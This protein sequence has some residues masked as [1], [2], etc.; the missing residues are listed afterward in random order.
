MIVF[1]KKHFFEWCVFA[2]ISLIACVL[3]AVR[4][5]PSLE[6]LNDTGRYVNELHGYCAGAPTND[7][8]Q[9]RKISFEI[10]YFFTSPSC[11]IESNKLFL[12]LV[13]SC[14]PLMFLMFSS[15]KNGT[16]IWAS[17]LL[18]SMYGVE[19][20]TNAMRQGLA[21]LIFFGG[22]SLLRR[23][24]KAA[25]AMGLLACA[26]HTSVLA[27]MP[28]MWWLSGI[29][30]HVKTLI[31]LSLFFTLSFIVIFVVKGNVLVEVY[32]GIS[33]LISYYNEMYEGNFNTLFILFITLP[34]Y[35]IHGLRY[36]LERKTI[37]LYERK[38]FLYSNILLIVSLI[39]YPVIA[40]RFAIFAIPLQIFIITISS[41]PGLIVGS[42]VLI[43]MCSHLVAM[44][45]LT[46]YY[47]VLFYG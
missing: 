19:L 5:I 8:L 16:I 22:V 46:D 45:F 27:F 47:L 24:T 44:Q 3:L 28:L 25:F 18:F 41:R 37:S 13:A 2:L 21:M 7:I 6:S 34:L 38:S 29:R 33:W 11:L 31:Y 17:S 40:Y 36:F 35:F 14:V 30:L 39:L 20:M 12:F 15:W 32:D 9:N 4:P 1:T 43:G 42:L 26:T 10:F 23:N